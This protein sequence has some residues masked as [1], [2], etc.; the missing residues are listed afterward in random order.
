MAAAAASSAIPVPGTRRLCSTAGAR[1]QPQPLGSEA[2]IIGIDLAAEFPSQQCAIEAG[3][4]LFVYSDGVFEI[5]K[6]DGTMWTIDEF[7]AFMAAAADHPGSQIER[8][9]THTRQLQGSDE[10]IDD[11]SIVQVGF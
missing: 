1:S 2:P 7:L 9:L 4:Q 3:D 6:T 10:F 8:L 11:F 5:P